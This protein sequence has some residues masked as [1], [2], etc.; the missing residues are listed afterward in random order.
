MPAPALLDRPAEP[1][2]PPP[3]PAGPLADLILARLL[4]A[5]TRPPTPTQVREAVAPFFT[6]PPTGERMG[7]VLAGL[8]AAG[9]VAA[10]GRRLTAAGRARALAYLGV[11]ELPPRSN[12]GTVR[13]K[14][15]MPKALGLSA[16]EAKK[17]DNAEPLAALLLKR[18]LGL[19]VGTG[20]TLNAVFEALVCRELGHPDRL[21][22]AELK[23]ALL[24]RVIGGDPIDGD[25][26][27]RVVPRVLL[28]ARTG[29]KA[30]LV[31][32][33]LRGW[34]DADPEPAAEDEADELF[35]LE[36]FANTVR[37]A[38]R[39]CPTGRFGDHKVFISHVWRSLADEPRFARLGADGFKRRLVEANRARLLSLSRVDMNQEQSPADLYGSEVRD[40]D[41]VFHFITHGVA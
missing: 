16:A 20:T 36:D 15:L 31:A 40:G 3:P 13:T 28:D 8:R 17:Y 12:W 1:P 34:A 2:A 39:D 23:A 37:S 30:G 22:L 38:A 6:R 9:L 24:G 29:G 35:D 27:K 14:Y 7:E 5:G 19:P 25:D 11:D 33:A 10:K 21:T 32:A 41:A 18:K 26:A 4:T